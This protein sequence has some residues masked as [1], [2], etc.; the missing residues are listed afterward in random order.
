V[1]KQVS[2]VEAA[3]HRG[4]TPNPTQR[5]P[6]ECVGTVGVKGSEYGWLLLHRNHHAPPQQ[7]QQQQQQQQ[8][9]VPMETGN[10]SPDLA[11][12]FV[13]RVLAMVERVKRDKKSRDTVQALSSFDELYAT[14]N[15]RMLS[16]LARQSFVRSWASQ[17]I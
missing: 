6:Q 15:K 7:Q 11:R 9:A 13:E 14:A 4:K 8:D 12:D 3:A 5:C 1:E 16:V 2:D 17:L 10:N